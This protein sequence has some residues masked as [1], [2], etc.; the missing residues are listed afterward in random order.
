ML[1]A[2]NINIL[3]FGHLRKWQAVFRSGSAPIFFEKDLLGT[4]CWACPSPFIVEII[5]FV[6]LSQAVVQMLTK[7]ESLDFTVFII[8]ENE[9]MGRILLIH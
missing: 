4:A 3:L 1:T 2:V 5:L 6:G 7:S 9:I 8:G